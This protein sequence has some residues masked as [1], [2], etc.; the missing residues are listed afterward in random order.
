LLNKVAG[1]QWI[2]QGNR[3]RTLGFLGKR[4]EGGR[5]RQNSILGEE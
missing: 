1:G 3:C 4:S 2:G 5:S